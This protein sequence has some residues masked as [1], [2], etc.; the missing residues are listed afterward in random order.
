MI[1]DDADDAADTWRFTKYTADDT[2]I[3]DLG[4]VVDRSADWRL[5]HARLNVARLREAR[6]A[7]WDIE[8]ELAYEERRLAALEEACR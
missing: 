7:G 4:T 8:P 3:Y 1:D 6:V 5:F 2:A